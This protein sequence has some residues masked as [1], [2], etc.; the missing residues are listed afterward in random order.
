MTGFVVWLKKKGYAPKTI[1][2]KLTAIRS[3]LKYCSAEDF[4]LHGVYSDVCN[5]KKQKEEKKA[6]EYLQ[7][8]AT[9]AILSA[10][11]TKTAKHRRNRMILILLYDTGA[12]VQE[13]SD[14]NVSS[15]HL[16]M[17]NPFITL[18]G[19][20]RKS[21]NVPLLQKTTGHLSVYLQEFH[22][23]NEDGP[24]LIACLMVFPISCLLTVSAWSLRQQRIR[25]GA[26]ATMFL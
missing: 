1:N 13:L 18:I 7:P 2:L 6:I 22:P 17:D 3:F 23:A 10:Y 11:D 14:L 12:R 20:G 4:E 16:D 5:V 9:A 19:K 21:R 26:H 15:L 25:Q 8:K 24:L